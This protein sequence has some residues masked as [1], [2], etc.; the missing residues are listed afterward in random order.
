MPNCLFSQLWPAVKKKEM[1]F[2]GSLLQHGPMS[3]LLTWQNAEVLGWGSEAWVSVF[4]WYFWL[5]DPR[6]FT[7]FPGYQF[8]H[9]LSGWVCIKWSLT[10]YNFY[11]YFLSRSLLVYLLLLNIAFPG[12]LPAQA[13]LMYEIQGLEFAFHSVTLEA[14]SYS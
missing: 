12:G 13:I 3:F 6:Q 1:L 5:Y 14:G 2:I 9:L 7:G 11:L 8:V 4:T 10:M